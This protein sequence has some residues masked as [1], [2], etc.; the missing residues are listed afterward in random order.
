MHRERERY[1]Y[2]LYVYIYDLERRPRYCTFLSRYVIGAL[3]PRPPNCTS[4]AGHFY[5][6]C[7]AVDVI[8]S[9]GLFQ[10]FVECPELQCYL[11]GS[12]DR[13]C[14]A[15]TGCIH[16]CSH[17]AQVEKRAGSSNHKKN[18][19]PKFDELQVSQN[20]VTVS[21]AHSLVEAYDGSL[22]EMIRVASKEVRVLLLYGI[23]ALQ[24][25]TQFSG[26]MLELKVMTLETRRCGHGNHFW[27]PT[28]V[29]RMCIAMVPGFT[30]CTTICSSSIW[31]P[32]IRAPTMF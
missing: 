5:H 16:V 6:L 31:R 10:P 30:P 7:D 14:Q 22:R 17:S 32:S 12:A 27:D 3:V 18:L 28:F 29:P 4:Q 11:R 23:P 1:V 26:A 19:S 24:P 21:G 2:I 8:T 25:G 20:L 9:F 15:D 13:N